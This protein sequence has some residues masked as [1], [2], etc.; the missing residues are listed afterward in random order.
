MNI[1][2]QYTQIPHPLLSRK[3]NSSNLPELWSP[4]AASHW[5]LVFPGFYQHPVWEAGADSDSS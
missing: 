4:G 2:R 1:P 3:S 5:A